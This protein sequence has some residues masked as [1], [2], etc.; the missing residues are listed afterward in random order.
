MNKLELA[1]NP[2]TPAETLAELAKDGYWHVRSNAA[3]NPNTP[4]ETLSEL[5]KDEDW[6]VRRC[7]ASNPNTPKKQRDEKRVK[8]KSI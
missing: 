7:T 1:K 5:A 2:N 3:R 6:I 8:N 4:I